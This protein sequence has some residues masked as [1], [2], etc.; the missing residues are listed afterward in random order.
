MAKTENKTKTDQYAFTFYVYAYM[1][2]ACAAIA[3]T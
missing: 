2:K 1:Q 3:F